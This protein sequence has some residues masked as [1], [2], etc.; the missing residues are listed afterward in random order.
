M[1]D[2]REGEIRDRLADVTGPDP[3][4]DELALLA[5]LIRSFLARTPPA[6]DRLGELLRGGD[7]AGVRDQAHSL[8]GSASNLGAG[9]LAGV[10]AEVEHAARDG[11]LT[12][13]DLT[14]SRVA[15]ELALVTGILERLATE[16][17]PAP[18]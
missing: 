11:Q 18:G 2:G 13:P 8:K 14:L 6:V 15:A 4:P 9:A 1:D 17:D 10:F 12:D 7:Q 16:F 5:R 3:D